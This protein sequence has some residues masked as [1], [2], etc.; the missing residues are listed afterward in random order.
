[1]GPTVIAYRVI[2]FIIE[3]LPITYKV[4]SSLR[5][6]RPYDIAKAAL[7]EVSA[8]DAFRVVDR[9]LHDASREAADRAAR[10]RQ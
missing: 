7:E 5:R 2:F 1:M 3:I 10:R 9:Y 4:I 8:I 6:R